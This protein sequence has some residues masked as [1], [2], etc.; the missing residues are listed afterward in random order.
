VRGSRDPGRWSWA[1]LVVAMIVLPVVAVVVVRSSVST[2][3]APS[4]SATVVIPPASTVPVPTEDR[5]PEVR[6]RILDADGNAVAGAAVRLVSPRPP[7]D[8]HADA[9]TDREG[10]F[11]F[12]RVTENAVRV[13]AAHDPEGVVSSAELLQYPGKTTEVVLVLSPAGVVRGIVV[14]RESRAVPGAAVSV[15]GVPWIA[16]RATSDDAGGFVVGAVPSEA[17]AVVVVARGYRTARVPLQRDDATTETFVHVTLV[18]AS[19]VAGLVVDD[20]GTP[21]AARVAACEGEPSEARVESGD[22]GAFELPPSAIGCS[23]VAERDDAAPSDATSVVE[24]SPL[25]LRLKAGGTIEGNVV[26]GRG[27]G[28]ASFQVAIETFASAHTRSF[29]KG[30]ARSFDDGRGAFRWEK[31]PPGTYVLA[32]SAGGRPPVRS[33]PIEV[34]AGAATRGTRIVLPTGGVVRGHVYDDHHEPLAGVEL[35]FD[36]V[37]SVL[38]SSAAA[39]TDGNGAYLLEGAPAGPF[40]L[41]A[42]KNGFRMRFV[43]ALRVPPGGTL[44]Q[45]VTLTPADGR[46]G[47]ELGGIGASLVPSP[48]GIKFGGVFPGDP[49][50]RAGL[51][52]GDRILRIDGE[53]TDSMSVADA[54]QR[55]RGEAGT[56][57][58]IS[59]LHAG[60]ADPVDVVV[61]RGSIVH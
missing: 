16:R 7:Y 42:Q 32:A 60:D 45:D 50:D 19:P 44:D 1:I 57:V 28:I 47:M 15:E 8:V 18:E 2:L 25:R 27:A 30:G 56:S 34:R 36:L 55:L 53:N 21:V 51:R 5:T 61:V 9:S 14:D 48:E 52:G 59:V 54:I 23:A 4:A 10:A 39:T 17:T 13:V 40:T 38:D 49:A 20:D 26:D 22:D 33:D 3:S 6:G 35:R 31:L 29:G 11:S 58:G 46:G 12:P 43:S 41:R 24:G 37:S